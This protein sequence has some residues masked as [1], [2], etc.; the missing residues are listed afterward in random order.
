MATESSKCISSLLHFQTKRRPSSCADA[1]FRGFT[2]R[3]ANIEDENCEAGAPKFR[4]LLNKYPWFS[5]SLGVRSS[6]R[7]GR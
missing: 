5:M 1:R 6:D 2:E 3:R 7:S 4:E